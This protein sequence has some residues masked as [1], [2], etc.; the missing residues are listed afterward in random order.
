M[1]PVFLLLQRLTALVYCLDNYALIITR[2]G[3]YSPTSRVANVVDI[4]DAVS[5]NAYLTT[6]YFRA[7]D[8]YHAICRLLEGEGVCYRDEANRLR[9]LDEYNVEMLRAAQDLTTRCEHIMARNSLVLEMVQ[10]MH[11]EKRQ[12]AKRAPWG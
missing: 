8:V 5:V 9:P 1:N 11:T 12:P 7:T 2:G 6:N 3:E 4:S 10:D